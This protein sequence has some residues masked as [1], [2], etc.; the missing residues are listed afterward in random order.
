MTH[1][2]G[3]EG[4]VGPPALYFALAL[5]WS[6]SF[7]GILVATGAD[8][9]APGWNALLY[10]GGA[11]PLLAGLAVAW[12]AGAL[13]KLGRR[14]VDPCRIRGVWWLAVL[15]MVPAIELGAAA[16]AAAAG[17]GPAELLA[18]LGAG[19]AA[20]AG[21]LAT[22]GFVLLLG[23][24]PE[25]IGWRGV[26]LDA[27]QAR[28]APVPASLLLGF[29]WA[30]WHAPLFLMAGYYAPFG[31]APAPGWFLWDILTLTLLIT[32]VHNHTRRSLLAA[33]LM[34]F[35]ANFSGEIVA[36][37]EAGDRIAS[38]LTTAVALAVAATGG[39]RRPA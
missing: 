39:L 7:W 33:V 17:A 21:F 22:A 3:G 23:P 14:L 37:S 19:L 36:A 1:G 28:L 24:L 5:A 32:W 27:L 18:A 13:G 29:G 31:G 9:W 35:L 4:G 38:V 12:R 11:G 30:L 16:S 2:T 20:P 25:E 6:W 8:P 15:G 10:A 34:H 26:A